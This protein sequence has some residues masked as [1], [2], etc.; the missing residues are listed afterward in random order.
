MKKLIR[1]TS[2]LYRLMV[3]CSRDALALHKPDGRFIYI[4]PSY[5]KLT[6][7]TLGELRHCTARQLCELLIHPQDDVWET[8][9]RL[10][11]GV[12]SI[13][14]EY[15]LRRKDSSYVWVATTSTRIPGPDRPIRYI[16]TSTHD[17]TERR[18]QERARRQA[19]EQLRK[20][21]ALARLG[22]WELDLITNETIWS[23]EFCRICGFDPET[24]QPS[25]ELGT[26]AIHPDDREKVAQALERTR[27]T[28]EPYIME[29]RIVHPDGKVRWVLSQDEAIRDDL[30]NTIRIVGTI[31]DITERREA[32]QQAFNAALERERVQ[33]LARFVRDA[34]HEFRTPLAIINTEAY[35]MA[36]QPDAEKRAIKAQQISDQIARTSRLLDMLL[37]MVR[38]DQEELLSDFVKVD[39][40][41]I[42]QHAH[43]RVH[44]SYPSRAAHLELPTNLP[45]IL[46][47]AVDLE[48][49]FAQVID[50]A[51]R[52]SPPESTVRIR[53]VQNQDALCL[54]VEDDGIGIAEEDQG[55]IFETFWRK[56]DAHSS[57]GFGLGLPIAKRIVDRH[58]GAIRVRSELGRGSTFCLSLPI[59]SMS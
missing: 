24:V 49:A 29:K 6:G 26:L 48:E 18:K 10:A 4:N 5:T 12:P 32:Q 19:E 36:R 3:H 17:I 56:D 22:S 14:L 20:A 59:A 54:Q 51:Y 33:I 13:T 28:G 8:F 23:E 42:A 40:R 11:D 21:Q 55:R 7:Y 2:Q 45:P 37:L 25:V 44:V 39:L 47:S 35:L 16:L 27:T 30:G 53:L 31:L 41:I 34:A 43:E 57:S 1:T 52:Y 58:G 38:M 15:R 50:N 9:Q 46:G